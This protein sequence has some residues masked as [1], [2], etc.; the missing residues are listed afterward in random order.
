MKMP[1]E[2]AAAIGEV[3]VKKTQLPIAK[4]I[5]LGILA[6]VY[7]GFGALIMTTVR[8]GLADKLGAGFASFLGGACFSVGLMLVV[9]GGSELFTGNCMMTNALCS[10]KITFAAMLKNWVFVYIGNFIGSI[11]L[12][13]IVF[14]GFYCFR[15]PGGVGALA[16]KIA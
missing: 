9:I 2:I 8:V 1:G 6:G 13:T 12:V 5:V 4:M 11:L 15:E 7:I 14:I 3:G 16:V 10:R